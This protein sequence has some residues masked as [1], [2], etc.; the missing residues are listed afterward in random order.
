MLVRGGLFSSKRTSCSFSYQ[1]S[2][3]GVGLFLPSLLR[4]SPSPSQLFLPPVALIASRR[5]MFLTLIYPIL[6]ESRCRGL[7][8][9]TINGIKPKESVVLFSSVE[10]T[11]RADLLEM[12]AEQRIVDFDGSGGLYLCHFDGEERVG[13]WDVERNGVVSDG[14]WEKQLTRAR[15]QAKK[16]G[17]K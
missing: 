1:S 5:S 8:A 2:E 15:A 17:K 4:L 13:C 3:C 10:I 11:V 12:L 6:V 9:F 16:A 7:K 14:W